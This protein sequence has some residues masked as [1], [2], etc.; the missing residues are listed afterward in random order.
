MS[1][2]EVTFLRHL[3]HQLVEGFRSTLE[4]VADSD[5]ILHIGDG[6]HAEGGDLIDRLHQ[7]RRDRVHLEH[8]ADGTLVSGPSNED[9]A[10]ELAAYAV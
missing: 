3:P 9:L 6:A 4:E 1:A 10:G 8:S 5:L 7:P 2:F